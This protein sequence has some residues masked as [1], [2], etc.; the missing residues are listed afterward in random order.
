MN[1]QQLSELYEI[2]R[3]KARYFRL[4]DTRQWDEWRDLFTDDLKFFIQ[5]SKVPDT[6]ETTP[7]FDGAD[8]LVGYLRKAHPDKITVHQGHMPE[9]EFIDENTATG[10]WALFDWVDDPGRNG[11]WKGYGH[12]HERYVRCPDGKWRISTVHLTRLRSNSVAPLPSE[13][14]PG[15]AP[16][17]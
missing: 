12:Y 1:T 2:Q 8:A 10:I 11:A 7:T 5:N 16:Q 14:A 4:M 13:A 17:S 6:T 9:I 3:L 15:P